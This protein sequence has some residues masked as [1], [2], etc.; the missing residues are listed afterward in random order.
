MNFSFIF[1]ARGS[2]VYSSPIAIW[3]IYLRSPMDKR[4]VVKLSSI[5]AKTKR[6]VEFV[7]ASLSSSIEETGVWDVRYSLACTM[8]VS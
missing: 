1:G 3:Y 4:V 5:D 8:I 2:S 7:W 6:A